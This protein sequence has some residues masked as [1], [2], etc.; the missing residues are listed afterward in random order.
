MMFRG[1]LEFASA[2]PPI[3]VGMM[4][5]LANYGDKQLSLVA[6]VILYIF[7]NTNFFKSY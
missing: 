7:S 6:M 1:L 2:P 5:I 3:K 4:Q